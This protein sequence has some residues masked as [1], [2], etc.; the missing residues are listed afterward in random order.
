M[1]L[2][3]RRF[4]IVVDSAQ[5]WRLLR[6]AYRRSSVL[7]FGIV[8]FSCLLIAGLC[9]GFWQGLLVNIGTAL[10]LIPPI[11]VTERLALEQE[12]ASLRSEFRRISNA[13]EIEQEHSKSLESLFTSQEE[14]PA[15]ELVLLMKEALKAQAVSGVGIAVRLVD[16]DYTLLFGLR[17]TLEATGWS[18]P[19]HYVVEAQET[20]HYRLL[21]ASDDVGEAD[22]GIETWRLIGGGLGST[23]ASALM[24]VR[25]ELLG[26]ELH[27]PR[28]LDLG[29]ICE[30]IRETLL[31]RVRFRQPS[32]PGR[33]G[34]APVI[35][36]VGK[37]LAVTSRGIES[38]F[39]KQLGVTPMHVARRKA[40]MEQDVDTDTMTV[41]VEN[42]GKV[43]E[44]LYTEYAQD[45][46]DQ[47]FGGGLGRHI[48][49]PL[50]L[51]AVKTLY[52]SGFLSRRR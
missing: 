31:T 21:T 39:D 14:Y 24:A 38:R 48:E 15:D 8:G 27:P 45:R 6:R 41:H 51:Q 49:A 37:E 35:M 2:F 5:W 25:E 44:I 47:A 7:A 34:M 9:D 13:Q 52:A 30:Q 36:L 16:D 23:T 32:S 20:V 28:E 26:R 17:L 46:E 33:T 22:F 18:F 43:E 1:K 11:V 12:V 3:G 10:L 50:A 19:P 4:K 40:G 42:G 29:W